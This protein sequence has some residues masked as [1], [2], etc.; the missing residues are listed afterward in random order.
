MMQFYMTPG[1][2]STGIH[3]L[4]EELGL[5]FAVHLIDLIRGDQR[6]TEYLAIN[7]NGTIPTL[8]TDSDGTFCDYMSIARYLG[9]LSDR[10][11]LLPDQETEKA[12]ILQACELVLKTIHGEGFLRYFV[13]DKFTSVGL[14]E[15][16]VQAAGLAIVDNNLP[17][18]ANHL[19]ESGYFAS[20]FSIADPTA[21]YV[22]FWAVKSGLCLP[23]PLRM[24]FERMLQRP[25]VR[26]VLAEEGYGGF[27]RRNE[28]ATST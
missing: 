17:R 1:S 10:A 28:E 8:V 16:E 27:L 4:L 26:Q 9:T 11:P 13:P 15:S 19:Q 21:F 23:A 5:V 7:P 3:I 2:C 22:C 20:R 18:L 6:R 12:S 14:S 24:H 25:A